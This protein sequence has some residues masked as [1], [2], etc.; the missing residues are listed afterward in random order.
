MD[1]K[2]FCPLWGMDS[3]SKE[4][5]FT[6]IKDAGFD[7]VEL[8]IPLDERKQNE[9]SE[10]LERFDL[11][12]I[13]QHYESQGADVIEYQ[14]EFE[15]YLKNAALLKPLFINSQTGR[16][17]YSF[18]DNIMLIKKADELARQ[19]G[20]KVIHE[21]HR[22]KFCFSAHV[23]LRYFEALPDLHIAADFSH[24]CNVSESLLQDQQVFVEKAIARTDHI[25][26]RIGHSQS[27]QVTDPR[28]PEW[29]EA[30]EAHLSWWDKIIDNHIKNGAKFLTI[31]P[32]FGPYP[33]MPALPFTQCPVAKQWDINVYMKR[34]LK[35][36]YDKK[37]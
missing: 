21:T 37:R 1:I 36:R 32:E 33:Y 6:K 7:G 12:L 10:L 17:Y 35:D 5:A 26:A 29:Q 28:A 18:E 25:H 24:W 8:G 2:F 19:Y 31:T 34:F 13:A 30:V 16:D 14:K 15:M 20:V 3:L 23:A 4:Q 9:I 11:L 27:A 22:G